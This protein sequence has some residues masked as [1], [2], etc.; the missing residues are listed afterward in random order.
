MFNDY[1][2]EACA[3]Y[4]LNQTSPVVVT[5]TF[6]GQVV[7]QRQADTYL[8][9]RLWLRD[10]AML[11]ACENANNRRASNCHMDIRSIA[12]PSVRDLFKHIKIKERL[13]IC[14]GGRAHDAVLTLVKTNTSKGFSDRQL[15]DIEQT[16]PALLAS[17][18]RHME[19]SDHAT[20]AKNALTSFPEIESC[21]SQSGLKLSKREAQVATRIIH[22]MS[23]GGIA[24]DLSI[25]QTTVDT[26]RK[27]LYRRLSIGSQHELIA[28]YLQRWNGARG[29]VG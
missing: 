17:L 26:Y 8:R 20:G 1:G 14:D 25:S 15:A 3:M 23:T 18:R 28:L 27:R 16:A 19:L 2:I 9:R 12:D 22:G 21:I 10:T 29:V 11:E 4:R 5:S 13:V 6:D 7:T 24:S